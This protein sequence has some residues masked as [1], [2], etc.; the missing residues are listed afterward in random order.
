VKAVLE[1]SVRKSGDRLRITAQLINVEDG[2]HIWSEKYDRKLEDIFAIQDEISLAIVDKLRIKL[3]GGERRDLVKRH[4]ADL[5]AHNLYLKGLYFWGRRLEV[6]LQKAMDHFRRAIEKDPGYALAYVGVADTYN[7]TGFF[8]YAPPKETFPKAIAA[9]RKALEI[10]ATL[11]EAQASLGWARTVYVWDWPR[12]QRDFKRAI[13]LNPNY[14]TAHE[15]YGIHLMCMG[16]FDEAIAETELARDLDPLSPI[17][18]AAVGVAYYYARRYD[19]SIANHLKALE[20]V[21]DFLLANTFIV[22]TYVFNGMCERALEI[23]SRVELSAAGHSYTMGVFGRA[24]GLCGQE[25]DA[26][27]VLDSLNDLARKRYVSPINQVAVLLGLG[28]LD[29]AFDLMERACAERAPMLAM[30]KTE[31]ANGSFLSDTRFRGLL[32]KIGLED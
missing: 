16:R 14:A 17:I 12:A 13:E 21:P 25:E 9:A 22:P 32:R 31:P 20:L 4:T 15:W 18:N 6:G 8:G 2:F 1:G 28:R 23:M 24:Y 10:D 5:E 26:L 29:E 19:E 30:S 3:L 11:G 27:R 7:V